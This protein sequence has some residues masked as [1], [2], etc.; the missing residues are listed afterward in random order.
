MS[1]NHSLGIC[2]LTVGGF[3]VFIPLLFSVLSEITLDMGL[4]FAGFIGVVFILAAMTHP[5]D[6][7]SVGLL[8][9]VLLIICIVGFALK[10]R[11]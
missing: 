7:G 5:V 10:S 1:I 11:R 4:I 9:G 8:G 3:I 2:V 6:E